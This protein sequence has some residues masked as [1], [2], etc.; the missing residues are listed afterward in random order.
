[1]TMQHQPHPD[2]ERLAALAGGDADASAD[3]G[4]RAHVS[5]CDRCGP[6]VAEL[7]QLRSAMAELPDLVPSRR[8][9]L[10]PPAPQSQERAPGGWL[11][12]LAAPMM[13]AGAVLVLV[14]SIAGSGTLSSVNVGF[15]GAAAA[16]SVA[17]SAAQDESDVAR[18][19]G[20][21]L[22]QFLSLARLRTS[23]PELSGGQP[24]DAVA[25]DS[26]G[27]G[28]KA[29]QGEAPGEP[30]ARPGTVSHESRQYEVSVTPW[31][32]VLLTGVVLLVVGGG[33]LV[34]RL[35]RGP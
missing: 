11:R 17:P 30:T 32:V 12:R 6:M 4:L 28:S 24:P 13:A 14:A 22:N 25:S 26:S 29:S 21:P 33:I 35:V 20:F 27:N 34:T 23:S 18:D 16:P 31:G 10:V 19:L 15:G 1:M 2:D 7:Q 3:A 9:Q 5:A 8:L